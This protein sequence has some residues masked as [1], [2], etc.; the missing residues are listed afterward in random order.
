M[1][2]HEVIERTDWK[3]FARQ[4]KEL[5]QVIRESVDPELLEGLLEWIDAIQDSLDNGTNQTPPSGPTYSHA[6]T[7]AFELKSQSEDGSDVTPKMFREAILKR[8]DDLDENNEW[9]EAIGLPY[10]T[11]EEEN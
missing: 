1:T 11:H 6:F 3:L 5:S 2:L 7:V 10:D 4:K 9:Q 8:M